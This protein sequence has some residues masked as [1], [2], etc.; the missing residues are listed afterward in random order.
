MEDLKLIKAL[1]NINL[2]DTNTAISHEIS[3]HISVERMKLYKEY[4]KQVSLGYKK[5][6]ACKRAGIKPSLVRRIQKEFDIL[7]PFLLKPRRKTSKNIKI[8]EKSEDKQGQIKTNKDKQRQTKTNKDQTITYKVR[9]GREMTA[10]E[11]IEDLKRNP[12]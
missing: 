7:S 10:D 3:T 5:D 11:V 4:Q 1:G 12:I 2:I 9:G 8:E 6:E